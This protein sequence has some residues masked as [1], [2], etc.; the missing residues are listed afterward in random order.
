M[1]ALI[2]L[3]VTIKVATL[4]LYAAPFVPILTA[5]ATNLHASPVV[6]TSVNAALGG[7]VAVVTT[8]IGQGTDVVL[9]WTILYKIALGVGVAVGSYLAFRKPVVEPIANAVPSGIG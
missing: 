5:L 7:I 4:T 9:R 6:K 3:V 1:L 2:L 8:A